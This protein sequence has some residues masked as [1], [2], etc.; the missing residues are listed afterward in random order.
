MKQLQA[1]KQKLNFPVKAMVMMGVLVAA[2]ALMSYGF[3]EKTIRTNGSSGNAAAK[4][5]IASVLAYRDVYRVLISARCVNCHPSGDI[6]L[7]GDDSRLHKMYPKRGAD[8]KGLYAMKCANC[9]QATNTPGL[10]TPPGN[11]EWHLPPANMKMVFQGRTP[12]QLALQLVDLKRN[13]NKNRQQLLD[14]ARDTLVKAG[15]NMGE[16]RKPPPM[17]YEAFV[18]AWNTWIEKGAYA[19]AK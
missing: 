9:H 3:D 18:K 2:V 15:W 7:Q 4:D 5:S 13:G 16:G 8:G 17:S 12:R 1:E 11:P 10:H 14:H 19:P 6:P